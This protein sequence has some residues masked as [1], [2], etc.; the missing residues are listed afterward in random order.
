MK[1][2]EL[3]ERVWTTPMSSLAKEFGLSD[4]GLAKKCRK[5]QI[6][7]PPVGY[8]AKVAHGKRV[9]RPKLPS[10]AD[11]RLDVVEF[12]ERPIA[13]EAP[14]LPPDP[15]VAKVAEIDI[16]RAQQRRVPV[17]A[18]S[19]RAFADSFTNKYGFLYPRR[20]KSEHALNIRVTKSSLAR[21]HQLF[22]LLNAVVS[23]ANGEIAV[24][25]KH[26][27]IVRLDDQE[28][29]L[30][31]SEATRQVDREP[32][33]A[34]KTRSWLLHNGKIREYVP[35]GTLTLS[36]SGRGLWHSPVKT[37]WR[38]TKRY[39]LEQQMPDIF[40]ALVMLS[41]TQWFALSQPHPDTIRSV[42][43]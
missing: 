10:I 40:Q 3:Y 8:W 30:A 18:E 17:V 24:T 39:T 14:S 35:T 41:T 19:R 34:E 20:D 16:E 12:D 2:E 7:R 13:A 31:L 28:I 1:R 15:R 21:A 29:E 23:E 43:W 27:T 6:P 25:D 4:Q 42:Y 5:H 38:D 26:K 11:R 33:S 22:A 32:T 9:I 36:I 37:T